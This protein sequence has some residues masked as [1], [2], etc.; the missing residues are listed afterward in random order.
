[1][2]DTCQLTAS[3]TNANIK[4]AVTSLSTDDASTERKNEN[5]YLSQTVV[6]V[7][8]VISIASGLPNLW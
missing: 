3:S 8:R 6:S 2:Y 1:M 4:G 7:C 5:M